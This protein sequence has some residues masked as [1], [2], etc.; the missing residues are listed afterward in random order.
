VLAR[1]AYG[2]RVLPTLISLVRDGTTSPVWTATTGTGAPDG[3]ADF[4]NQPTITALGGF[5]LR[6]T[7]PGASDGVSNNQSRIVESLT[8]CNDQLCN[9]QFNAAN[10]R[11]YG[12]ITTNSDFFDTGLQTNTILNTAIVPLSSG[13][14]DNKC[15]TRPF[16]DGSD[17]RVQGVGLGTTT[18]TTY[19]LLVIPKETIKKAGITSRNAAS[20][21]VC[22]GALW[23]D[24][25]PGHSIVKWKTKSGALANNVDPNDPNRYWGVPGDCGAATLTATDPC[26]VLRTKQAADVKA[27]L[28]L[29][30]TQINDLMKDSD[31]AIIIKK[32]FPWDGRGGAF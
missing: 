16:T 11:S 32:P 6:A 14:F 5:K 30:T 12:K 19:M 1:D 8:A 31:L 29:S 4:L 22:L 3:V 13:A 21:N 17:L 24:P 26:I 23:I 28:G 10:V 2:N 18:P 25:D 20:F 27:Y 15:A 9:N 7:T